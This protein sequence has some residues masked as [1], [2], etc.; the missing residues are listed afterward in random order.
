M[1]E[2]WDK[3]NRLVEPK[4]AKHF[5]DESKA[6]LKDRPAES[7]DYNQPAAV[8]A[9]EGQTKDPM[10]S[11]EACVDKAY[12]PTELSGVAATKLQPADAK[13]GGDKVAASPVKGGEGETVTSPSKDS[14]SQK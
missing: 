11:P 9:T 1:T 2:I 4:M 12:M 13:G 14:D 8:Q 3:N 7:I 5:E 6:V 10:T